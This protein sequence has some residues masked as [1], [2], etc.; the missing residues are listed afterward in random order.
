MAGAAVW[1]LGYDAGYL[2]CWNLVD[3]NLSI[4]SV[5]PLS[6][7]L[8]DMGGYKGNYHNSEN[9]TFS[10]APPGTTAV[11]LSFLNFDLEANYD[12]LIIYDGNNTTAPVL[13]AL[14]G[15]NLPN[16]VTST[17]PVMT[18]RFH[19]DGSYHPNRI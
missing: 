12:S 4:C 15:A 10:I 14:T 1:R 17:G 7:T 19:S 9:Y 2:D 6:D 5:T 13:A 16:T 8:Y 11:Q 3:R 18:I